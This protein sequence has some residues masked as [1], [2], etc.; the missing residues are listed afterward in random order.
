MAILGD[1]KLNLGP[2]FKLGTKESCIKQMELLLNHLWI[3]NVSPIEMQ[4]IDP[5]RFMMLLNALMEKPSILI[6]KLNSLQLCFLASWLLQ[7]RSLNDVNVMK[8]A[9][10]L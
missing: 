4:M 8:R 1:I 2:I 5:I 6:S 3:C 7:D 10:L 9:V